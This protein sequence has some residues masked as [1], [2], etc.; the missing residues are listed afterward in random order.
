[1]RQSGFYGCLGKWSV[2]NINIWMSECWMCIISVRILVYI[3]LAVVLQFSSMCGNGFTSPTHFQILILKFR[4]VLLQF[5]YFFL[6]FFLHSIYCCCA[7]VFSS[8]KKWGKC[9]LKDWFSAAAWVLV[10]KLFL[11]WIFPTL[12]LQR[13]LHRGLY[14]YRLHTEWNTPF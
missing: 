13:S 11:T 5:L 12:T 4:W 14:Q 3:S 10:R 6:F 7:I 2:R 8:D 1:M 9:N